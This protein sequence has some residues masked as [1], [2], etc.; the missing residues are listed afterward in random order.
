MLVCVL[1]DMA[2]DVMH[3][4]AVPNG[5]PRASSSPTHTVFSSPSRKATAAV[6][7]D[8]HPRGRQRTQPP[9][10]ARNRSSQELSASGSSA[11]NSPSRS[12]AGGE[13]L[14]TTVSSE[15]TWSCGP[16]EQQAV[17]R[18]HLCRRQLEEEIDVSV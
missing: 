3:L 10:E 12:S 1:I 5:S 6:T 7:A 18:I 9:P 11:A 15:L 16:E 2:V 8:I 14:S 13:S 17:E 4:S